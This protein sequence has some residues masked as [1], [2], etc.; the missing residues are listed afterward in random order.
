M[1]TTTGDVLRPGDTG[2]EE[3]RRVWNGMIDRRPALIVR[4]ADVDDVAAAVRLA[5]DEGLPLA[6]RGGGHSVAGHSLCD[7]GLVL[8]LARLCHVHVDPAARRVRVGGGALLG[9]LDRA[10]QEHALAV[11]AGHVSHTGVGG[12]T[13]G[14]GTGWLM[15]RFGLTVDSLRAAEVVTADGELLRASDDENPDLF[16]ALRGGGGN[17]GVVTEF[18]F[19]AHPLGPQVVAGMLVYPLDRAAEMIAFCRGLMASA[20]DE[21]TTFPVLIT[22]PPQPPFPPEL[23]GRPVLALGAAWAGPVEEGLRGVAELKASGPALD[24][25]GPMPYA[26]LQSMLDESVPHGLHHYNHS[27]YL[28]ELPDAAI[29][30]LVEHYARVPSP[31]AQLITARMGGAIERVPPGATAFAHRDARYLVWIVNMWGPGDDPEP[32]IAWGRELA[33]ALKPYASGA[34]YVNALGEEP[35][36]VRAAYGAN[37][38]R[39]VELKRRYDP[40][41]VFRLNANVSPQAAS[42]SAI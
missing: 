41:N 28:D 12:L 14:G 8:D 39:L 6:V 2:Y 18:E 23:Q 17:F 40:D 5:R 22:A 37:W 29:D 1:L 30:T 26:A 15:R 7:D 36:R 32:N 27:D 19:E 31:R 20:P 33:A 35:H 42:S 16:W 25:L 34:V 4:A 38:E 24:L 21:L 13:L 11:P 3:A 10:T 9:Q